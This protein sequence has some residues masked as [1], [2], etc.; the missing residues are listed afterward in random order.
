MVS[1]SEFLGAD[2]LV[3]VAIG[4]Q[5]VLAKL[6]GNR[7]FEPDT[8]ITLGFDAGNVHLFDADAKTRISDAALANDIARVSS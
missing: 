2:T 8:P 5:T 4:N 1:A 6:S 3:E 7:A